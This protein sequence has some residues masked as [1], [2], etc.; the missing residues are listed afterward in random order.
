MWPLLGAGRRRLR[1]RQRAPRTGSTC[2]QQ[3]RAGA[4]SS[5]SSF[6]GLLPARATTSGA[7][8]SSTTRPSSARST[9]SPTSARWVDKWIVDGIIAR[10]TA[11]RRRGLRHGPA[12]AADR[13]RAGLR[14]G[15]WCVGLG[16]IGWFFVA[17]HADATVDARRTRPA[18]YTRHGGARP[19]LLATAGTRTATASSTATTSARSARS[20]FKLDVDEKR[21]V[22]LEVKNAFGRVAE[23]DFDVEPVAAAR[24]VAE[25]PCRSTTGCGARPTAACARSGDAAGSAG[26]GSQPRQPGVRRTRVAPSTGAQPMSES[27]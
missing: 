14:R 13:P 12:R 2:M 17:P 11:L 9:R 3:G 25:A 21:S 7:S 15:R 18:H 1:G 16:G 26:R 10:L 8:T 22:R 4:S 20:T 19:R 5:P 27:P 24:Q 6:P 23:R